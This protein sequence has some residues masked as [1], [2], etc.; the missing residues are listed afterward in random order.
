[1]LGARWDA[2][3]ALDWAL[4]GIRVWALDDSYALDDAYTSGRSM[5]L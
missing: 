5:K 2:G 3:W 4:D 1:M